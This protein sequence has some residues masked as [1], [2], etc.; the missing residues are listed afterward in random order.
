MREERGQLKGH[1]VV[2]EPFT[3]WGSCAGDVTVVKG[4]KFY[5]RGTVYGDLTVLHGGRVHVYGNVTGTML[6]KDGAK[7]ILSGTIGQ[8]CIN[9]GGR[10]TLDA[11]AHVMGKLIR[12]EDGETLIDPKAV[13]DG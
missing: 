7:V 8:D 12:S 6:V 2:S 11:A 3:L 9:E 5:M 1:Q 4:S 10:L 13:I